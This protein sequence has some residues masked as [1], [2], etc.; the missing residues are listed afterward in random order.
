MNRHKRFASAIVVAFALLMCV[1]TSARDA[2]VATWSGIVTSQGGRPIPDAVV[3][4]R[5]PTETRVGRSG[6]DGRVTIAA[7]PLAVYRIAV[8]APG[9]R[10]FTYEK[11]TVAA[12]RTIALTIVLR[13]QP[14][15]ALPPPMKPAV[16]EMQAVV[17]VAPP[18]AAA[19]VHDSLLGLFNASHPVH[20]P[21]E[22][23][24]GRYSYVLLH[25]GDTVAKAK[26]RAFVTKLVDR[27]A[28]SGSTIS[29][30][31]ATRSDNPLSYNVFFFPVSDGTTAIKV[32]AHTGAADTIL[33]AYDYGKARDLRAAYCDIAAH[34]SRSLCAVPYGGGPVL[35]TFLEPLAP[36]RAKMPPA[37]AYDFT[38][39][40]QDQFDGP[41]D[42]VQRKIELPSGVAA[43]AVL[44]PSLATHVANEL[45]TLAT[46]LNAG[47]TGVRAW[48]D[49]QPGAPHGQ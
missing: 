29:F 17:A 9:Y 49:K 39:V 48:I 32:T 46:A 22:P 42:T 5:S 47:I 45:D 6:P 23:Y 24:Y 31:D 2:P 16:P 25:D 33:A 36:S 40:S 15:A 37:F 10:T 3:T 19:D 1:P 41:L 26:N 8:E 30:S 34:A 4:L 21:S 35:L 20:T 13:P 28:A 12:E 27:F 44:P 14:T 7:L 11:I 18:P 38:S 43:D